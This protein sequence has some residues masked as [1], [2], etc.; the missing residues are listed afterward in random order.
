MRARTLAIIAM[1]G[2]S[3]TAAAGERLVYRCKDT[4]SG[5][6]SFQSQPCRPGQV[7]EATYDATPDKVSGKPHADGESRSSS[8]SVPRGAGRGS[9]TTRSRS[10]AVAAVIGS[11]AKCKRERAARDKAYRTDFKMGYRERQRWGERVRKACK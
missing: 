11:S 4:A 8:A 7:Q 1:L 5:H 9:R 6:L 3:G 10:R 2:L